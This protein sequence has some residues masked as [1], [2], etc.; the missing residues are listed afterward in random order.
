MAKLLT[1]DQVRY[2]INMKDVVNSCEAT[3]AGL[4]DGT[5]INPTKVTLDVGE[6]APYPSYDG[7]F[8]AMPAYIG[9]QKP[10]IA[11]IKWV[12][13]IGGY[14]KKAG[15]PF[16]GGMILLA[17][18]KFGI[19]KCVMDGKYITNLRTGAQ[20][21]IA[22][23]HIFKNK[24]TIRLGLFGAGMQGHTQ[25]EAISHCFDIEEVRVYDI[26]HPAAEKYKEN[27][28]KNNTVTGTVTICENPREAAES[29]DAIICVT[30]AKDRFL[31]AEWI[32]PGTVVMPLGSYDEVEDE[33]IL[34][35]D[36]IVI[37]HLGQCMH[38]GAL[39]AL[40]EKGQLTPADVTTTIGDLVTNRY[41]LGDISE[42]RIL[43]LPIGMGCLD[44]GAAG[45]VYQR[46]L[47]KHIGFEFDF[48]GECFANDIP[49]VVLS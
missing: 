4:S 1:Y 36:A 34:Q 8:N 48:N 46:A 28:K 41:D 24:K 14:R 21:A 17:D 40:F 13:G 37:D 9:Y 44:I 32:K 39:H 42:K 30:Q 49:E 3:F 29:V 22:L 18:P 27:M 25:T 20:S 2:L 33:V 31:K 47:E 12:L 10:D 38:R 35:S 6:S 16:I 19:F 45:I 15:L 23:K 43:C 11:G 5:V 26:F 7:F